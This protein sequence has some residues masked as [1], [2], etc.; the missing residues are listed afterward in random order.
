MTANESSGM[1]I[2][3]EKTIVINLHDERYSELIV[4]VDDP[5]AAVKLIQTAL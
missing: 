4:K 5:Q 3:P 1:C 2:T